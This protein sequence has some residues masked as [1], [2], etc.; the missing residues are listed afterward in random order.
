MGTTISCS[1]RRCQCLLALM[2]GLLIS[3]TPAL[4]QTTSG[5]IYGAIVD[6]SG[7]AVPQATV[8]VTNVQTNVAQTAT[9]NQNGEYTFPVVKPGDYKVASAL[10]GF[11]SQTQQGIRVDANQNVHVNFTLQVGSES[12]SI[13]VEAGTTLVDTRESQ[14]GSTV[15]QKR[16]QDLPLN[17]RNAYDLLTILP[18]VTNYTPDV[19]TG[20][21]QGTQIV[22]NGIPTQSTAYYLDGSYDTNVWRFG[23]NLLPNPDALQEFRVLTSNFDAEFGRSAGGVVSAITRSGTNQYHG[24]GIRL[25][26]QQHLQREELLS[27]VGGT[28]ASEPVWRQLWWT[29]LGHAR[30]RLPFLLISR[31]T[32]SSAGEC[33]VCFADNS[34]GARTPWRL[35]HDASKFSSG[36]VV[37]W[38]AVRDL[39]RAARPRGAEPADVCSGGQF[40]CR[41]LWPSGAAV[42]QRKHH[43][44]PR[45][46]RASTITSATSTR[47]P[48]CILSRVGHRTLPRS[49]AIRLSAMPVCRTTKASTTACSAMCGRL[50]RT[51]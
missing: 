17:G 34:H 24:S 41:Q 49:A 14:I 48:R 50:R 9:T 40:G 30:P 7:A 39:P 18:G 11:Q 10:A 36:R 27:D 47:S 26:S 22:V 25:S 4:A 6:V 20:S 35:P 43:L 46:W 13:T 23:G 45:V 29:R 51:R 12:T 32:C 44:R 16:I 33:L 38:C 1:N 21:R 5:S 2:F 3:T 15:D 31:A 42:G 37:Q 19:Q 8:T 28:P